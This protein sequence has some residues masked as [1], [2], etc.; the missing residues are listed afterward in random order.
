MGNFNWLHLSDLHLKQFEQFDISSM[1][2]KLLEK[3]KELEA[4]KYIFITGDIANQFEYANAQEIINEIKAATN[5]LNENVFWSVGN[6]DITRKNANRN[7]LIK[8]MRGSGN[9]SK[10]KK[11]FE[12]IIS[13]DE[14]RCLLYDFEFKTY[15]EKHKEILGYEPVGR[16]HAFYETDDLCIINLNTC[17]TSFDDNDAH[18]LYVIEPN[19]LKL[20][21]KKYNKPVFVLGHHSIDFFSDDEKERIQEMFDGKVDLYLCGHAHR[22]GYMAFPNTELEIH[23]IT[24]GGGICDNYSVYSFVYGKYNSDKK[25]I[26]VEPY[27]YRDRG[28]K[29]WRQDYELH[30]KLKEGATFYFKRLL[31]DDERKRIFENE[32]L[33]AS[34]TLAKEYKEN[35]EQIAS[36]VYN[37]IENY[38]IDK[39][40]KR[41]VEMRGLE[42]TCQ[43]Y[44]QYFSIACQ[45]PERLKYIKD[46][47]MFK[48]L[49]DII[50][51]SNSKF[52]LY[53][54]GEIGTGKSS[55]LTLLYLSMKKWGKD[56]VP[57][58][59]DLHS[60]EMQDAQIAIQRFETE[61]KLF[62]EIILKEEEKL[63]ILI[64]DGMDDH[65]RLIGNLG[66]NWVSK[67][68]NTLHRSKNKKIISL[69]L[70][71]EGNGI[72]DLLKSD[73]L[74]PTYTILLNRLN[75]FVKNEYIERFVKTQLYD[76]ESIQTGIDKIKNCVNKWRLEKADFRLLCMILDSEDGIL[77]SSDTYTVFLNKYCSKL[78]HY[79]NTELM[80]IA[81]EA[82]IYNE[83]N[84]DKNHFHWE[85]Y[86]AI[87]FKHR[88]I[89]S[90]LTSFYYVN[91]LKGED[92][93]ERKQM[94]RKQV[95]F[96]KESNVHIKNL[97]I[98]DTS[99][100]SKMYQIMKT[101]LSYEDISLDMKAQL[102]YLLPRVFREM[103][104]EAIRNI[105]HTQFN[106]IK[107]IIEE[108]GGYVSDEHDCFVNKEDKKVLLLLRSIICSL[109]ICGDLEPL[110]DFIKRILY[111]KR[112]RHVNGQFYNDYYSNISK[113]ISLEK[114]SVAEI[115]KE[116][117][118]TTLLQL[119]HQILRA[120]SSKYFENYDLFVLDVVTYFTIVQECN[121]NG[122]RRLTNEQNDYARN[123][124]ND[125]L[126]DEEALKRLKK[127]QELYDYLY[128]LKLNINSDSSI[129]ILKKLYSLKTSKRAG[130][131]NRGIKNGESIADHIYCA[132]LLGLLY[133]PQYK[134]QF[135]DTDYGEY[136]KEKV[137]NMILLHDIGESYTGDIVSTQ[138]TDKEK[139]EEWQITKAIFMSSTYEEVPSLVCYKE[140]WEEFI[141]N[142]TIN[143]KLAH[144][145]DKIENMVQILIYRKEGKDISDFEQWKEYLR[146]KIVTELGNK[147]FKFIVDSLS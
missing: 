67:Q 50:I 57:L 4:V 103:E 7:S 52:P 28:N 1:R 112:Y 76:D 63:I 126:N 47:C 77:Q 95:I 62:E 142:S 22:L 139:F 122:E 144:E 127:V 18:N 64:I 93:E 38:H 141:K 74:E 102:C 51:D 115:S 27:S 118:N 25:S 84:F 136:S 36:K 132:F 135:L 137:L 17:I 79:K 75:I 88:E 58:Y 32:N 92:E 96:S 20:F 15:Y 37:V 83:T 12:D 120:V 68:I 89:C 86:N 97:I 125:L 94:L 110:Y 33:K 46:T 39:R 124:L 73:A 117:I 56:I 131:E 48:E 5:V 138:K 44:T 70:W 21:E 61:T 10:N 54:T 9:K 116:S 55:F 129:G 45:I 26:R 85:K 40:V 133:L 81:K 105:L 66:I 101:S 104:R 29:K 100:Q 130:W 71:G 113:D 114:I 145:F 119:R 143:A 43:K 87:I 109:A 34:V 41:T 78:L 147:I 90:F 72:C 65:D 2:A 146:S 106:E 140:I 23:E 98:Y 16:P 91:V 8:R 123:L 111:D 13:D 19:L 128:L 35:L 11:K 108:I 107:P 59:F 99:N 60:Y 42:Q 31:S 80:R 24:C 30:R 134:P 121:N 14:N 69:G 49:S 3:L 53:I 82:F 6:H